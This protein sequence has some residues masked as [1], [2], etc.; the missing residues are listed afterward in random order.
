MDHR[1]PHPHVERL[2]QMG[3]PICSSGMAAATSMS[4][5]KKAAILGPTPWSRWSR[6]DASHAGPVAS[7][8]PA[9][10]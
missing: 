2:H 7:S 3:P 8:R 5:R 10:A 4:R 9:Q 1:T 6:V